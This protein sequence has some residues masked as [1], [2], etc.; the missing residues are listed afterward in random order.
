MANN[1]FQFKQFRVEQHLCAMKVSSDACIQ[2]A[3]AALHFNTPNTILDIGTGTGLLSLM[4]AQR[5][6]NAHIT[7]TEIDGGAVKQAHI[8]FQ[9]SNWKERITIQPISIQEFYKQNLEVKFDAI[10]S[11][12]PFFSKNLVSNTLQKSIARHEISLTKSE[13]AIAVSQLL[14]P[15]G[16]F[17]V[18]YPFPEWEKWEEIA[19][20]SGL[21]V[22]NLYEIYTKIGQHPNRI[23]AIMSKTKSTK[24]YHTLN[25]RNSIGAYSDAY[26]SLIQDWYL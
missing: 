20:K 19:L 9:Q 25:I 10:I 3:L 13:L 23:I 26:K 11:N 14:S 1:Y 18:M 16:Q 5:F 8:N 6:S 21:F 15:N 17:C 2:G 24:F 4:M 22:N 12:P 7:A